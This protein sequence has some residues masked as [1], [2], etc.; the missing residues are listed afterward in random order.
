VYGTSAW[1]P[2]EVE[3]HAEAAGASPPVVF[4]RWMKV[5]ST[6]RSP[7]EP[8]AVHA[9]DSF[10]HGIAVGATATTA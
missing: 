9:A 3:S 7:S 2:T 4:S 8:A 1:A 10:S 5:L 6:S